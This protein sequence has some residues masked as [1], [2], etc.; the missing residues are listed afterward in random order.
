MS[1]PEILE[2]YANAIG[3]SLSECW[4]RTE[5]THEAPFDLERLR[6]IAG[7]EGL[8]VIARFGANYDVEFQLSSDVPPDPDLQALQSIVATE[9][10]QL[11]L[12]DAADGWIVAENAES[13]LTE[14]EVRYERRNWCRSFDAF[15]RIVQTDWLQIA[16]SL[17]DADVVVGDMMIPLRRLGG[18]TSKL[19]LEPASERPTHEGQRQ[20]LWD[21]M[22]LL[23]DAAAWRQIAIDETRSAGELVVALHRDQSAVIPVDLTHARGG[24]VLWKWLYATDD[25]NRDDALRYILRFLTVTAEQIPNGESVRTLAEHYRIALSHDK[26]AEVQRAVSEGRTRTM[27]GMDEARKDL[28]SYIEETVKTAQ[29]AVIAAFGIVALVARNPDALPR[30]LL[31]LVTAVAI[32]GVLTLIVNRWCRIGDLGLTVKSL[33]EELS[34]E[35]APLLPE[36]ERINLAKGL[37][38]FDVNRKIRSGRG[39]VSVLGLLAITVILAAGVWIFCQDSEPASEAEDTTAEVG[40]LLIKMKPT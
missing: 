19:I 22:M 39:L 10:E 28:S 12:L 20:Q 33:R 35:K 24:L 2:I 37:E 8:T 13:V 18:D 14:I 30:W 11:S 17:V 21:L 9:S 16:D 26:A 27:A 15:N 5:V 4:G 7:E 1:G 25:A 23:A 38:K 34:Q 31:G 32:I 3:A 6:R 36:S 40:Y 29:A